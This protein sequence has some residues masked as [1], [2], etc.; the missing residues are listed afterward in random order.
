MSKERVNLEGIDLAAWLKRPNDAGRKLD[1]A[2][3]IMLGVSEPLDF[4]ISFLALV[5][6]KRL[7]PKA[8]AEVVLSVASYIAMRVL[9]DVDEPM[10]DDEAGRLFTA[11]AHLMKHVEDGLGETTH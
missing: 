7:G 1:T 10:P 8:R 2:C 11:T 9:S 4:Q 3:K 5:L 6:G